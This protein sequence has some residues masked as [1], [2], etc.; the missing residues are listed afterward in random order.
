MDRAAI[1]GRVAP[2]PPARASALA[3]FL[4]SRRPDWYQK[5]K[6]CAWC[7]TVMQK[8]GWLGGAEV[9]HGICSQ[10]SRQAHEEIVRARKSRASGMPVLWVLLF[11]AW[12]AI[13]NSCGRSP[14]RIAEQEPYHG[15]RHRAVSVTWS[16]DPERPTLELQP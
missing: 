15:T 10:C 8:A 11:F 12:A 9:S 5:R 3:R 14:A 2:R 7:Q 4:F 1:L 13:G 6:V 16:L